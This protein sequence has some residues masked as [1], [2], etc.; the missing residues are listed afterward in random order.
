MPTLGRPASEKKLTPKATGETIVSFVT[1]DY[2]FITTL[3][4]ITKYFVICSNFR[5]DFESLH[6][7]VHAYASYVIIRRKTYQVEEQVLKLEPCRLE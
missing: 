4:L 6:L 5:F 1:A 3:V 2:Y 7:L